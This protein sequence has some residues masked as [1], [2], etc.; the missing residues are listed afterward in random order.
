MKLSDRSF[1]LPGPFDGIIGAEYFLQLLKQGKIK[2]P[3]QN[4][5][6]QNTVFGWIV[7][8][9]ITLPETTIQ[10]SCH[11]LSTSL[12]EQLE[13][14]WTIENCLERKILSLGERECENH[15][16]K[17]YARCR[18]WK[19]LRPE[20]KEAYIENMKSYLTNGNMSESKLACIREEYYLPHH[21]VIK[22]SSLTTQ[23]RVVFDGSSKSVTGLSLND[24][25]MV[26]LSMQ[27]N[28]FSLLVRFR[29]ILIV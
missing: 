7:A 6:L 8:G 28:L 27:E 17:Y 26:G 24:A 12:N 13:K 4:A 18:N 9:K 19:I 21:V 23:L 25:L 1:H 14:F 15:Y 22:N 2:V 16:K 5:I 20:I 3:N 29:S 11:L 10:M